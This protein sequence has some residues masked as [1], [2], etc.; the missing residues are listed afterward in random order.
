MNLT[1]KYLKAVA[2]LAAGVMMLASCGLGEDNN[3]SM[4]KTVELTKQEIAVRNMTLNGSWGRKA[5]LCQQ[6]KA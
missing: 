1:K 4:T 6:R 2:S 5:V 3:Q